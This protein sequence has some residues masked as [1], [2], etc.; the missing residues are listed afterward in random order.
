MSK[1]I[2][3]PRAAKRARTLIELMMKEMHASL[4]DPER[5]TAEQ[6][7]KLFG[8]KQSMIANLHKLVATLLVLPD[9]ETVAEVDEKNAFKPINSEE[10]RLLTAWLAE[11]SD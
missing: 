11:E 3:S 7:D 6:W 10:M 1:A 9:M 5:L 2:I 8:A 4:R